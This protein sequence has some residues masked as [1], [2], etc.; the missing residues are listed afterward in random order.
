MDKKST[1]KSGLLFGAILGGLAAFFLSPKSGK[2]NR[3]MAKKKFDELKE[4]MKDKD[5]D[6]IAMEIYG[7]ASDEGKKLYVS[8]RKQL[9]KRLDEM[10]DTLSDIDKK[11][12]ME[13]VSDVMDHVKEETEATKDRVA[14]LQEY[15][16]NRWD[17]A[18]T[19]AKADAK[20]VVKET[21]A[22]AK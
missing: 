14:K 19:M 11:K 2:E 7:K 8:A 6:E 4:K 21:K 15:L 12:Y 5:L 16:V 20:E 17:D 1:F 3:E 18:Q 22:K 9:D 13:L 10:N